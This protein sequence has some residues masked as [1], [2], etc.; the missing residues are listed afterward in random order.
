MPIFLFEAKEFGPAGPVD[1]RYR[2]HSIL[3]D[4]AGN[5]WDINKKFTIR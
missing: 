3:M 5:G 4:Q 2:L 1:G